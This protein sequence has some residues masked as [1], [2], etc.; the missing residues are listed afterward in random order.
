MFFFFSSRRRHTRFDCDWSSDVCSSDLV[1]I[2][3]GIVE[4]TALLG[5]ETLGILARAP[6]VPAERPLPGEPSDHCD[7]A[8]EVLA[9][10]VLRHILVVDP[11]PAVACHL[12]AELDHGARRLRIALERHG[13]GEDRDRDAARLEEAH[14]APEAGPAAIFVD[15][16]HAQMALPDEGR[17]ADDLGEEG[18]R[19]AIAM[20]DGVLAA[21][22]V[23][24]DD[25]EG[26][27]RPAWP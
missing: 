5:D 12:V 10:D 8:V 25:L 3:I 4:E 14:H 2:G 1:S 23:I 19:R 7:G 11:A 16:L 15:R 21:F 20:Q 22:L 26:K 24:D 18:F 27:T 17:R 13:D 9:L 6:G